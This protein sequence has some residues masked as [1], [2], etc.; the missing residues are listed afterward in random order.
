MKEKGLDP[1]WR[2]MRQKIANIGPDSP[3]VCKKD[4][5]MRA[6]MQSSLALCRTKP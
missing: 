2:R 1:L 3:A 6:L 5:S 4:E